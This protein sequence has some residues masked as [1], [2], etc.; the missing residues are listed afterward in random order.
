MGADPEAAS[1]G[2]NDCAVLLT[3]V[4]DQAGMGVCIGNERDD[5]AGFARVSRTDDT[6]PLFLNALD[7]PIGQPSLLQH[8]T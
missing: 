7:E 5:A 6:V 1:A 3:K 2:G 8:G 4:R